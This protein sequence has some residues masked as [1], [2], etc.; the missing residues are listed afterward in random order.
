MGWIEISKA[1]DWPGIGKGY[2]VR[3]RG[4]KYPTT[5]YAFDGE[6]LE[7]KISNVFRDFSDDDLLMLKEWY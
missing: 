7:D 3:L 1:N 5:V 2:H 4:M 6:E